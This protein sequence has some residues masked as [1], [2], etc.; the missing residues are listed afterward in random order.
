MKNKYL[1]ELPPG[2]KLYLNGPDEACN[3]RT[4]MLVT[5]KIVCHRDYRPETNWR[6]LVNI[7][8]GKLV[9]WC[10]SGEYGPIPN[11]WRIEL[12]RE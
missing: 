4:I 5:D 1:Y 12:P 2:T 7:I 6:I 3:N 10:M 11:H 8:D 9:E